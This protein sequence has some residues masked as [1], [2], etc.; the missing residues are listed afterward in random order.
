M[1]LPTPTPQAFDPVELPSRYAKAIVAILTAVLGI[2]V[3]ALSDNR[4][5]DGEVISI[6]IALLTA[7][8]VYLV[9]ELDAGVARIAKMIVAVLGT[10]AQAVASVL[11]DGITPQ[12]WV[13]ILVAALGAVSVGIIPN[14]GYQPRHR[15][16]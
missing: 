11:S 3:T 16:A 9:P 13:I 1:A 8:G 6:V 12:E 10:I 15:A 14:T 2:V 5:T 7:I 4:F